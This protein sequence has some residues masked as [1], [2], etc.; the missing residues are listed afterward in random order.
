MRPSWSCLPAKIRRCW[1]AGCPPC[2]GSSPH[3]L[4]RV[5][6]LDA[7]RDRLARESLHKMFMPPPPPPPPP[8]P[9]EVREEGAFLAV[10]ALPRGSA[11]PRANPRRPCSTPGW[12]GVGWGGGLGLGLGTSSP[13]FHTCANWCRLAPSPSAG[14]SSLC[15][16]S[17]LGA[18]RSSRYSS[19]AS[20]ARPPRSAGWLSC[21]VVH[22]GDAQPVW[23]EGAAPAGDA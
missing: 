19:A 11:P 17:H 2:P 12:S 18:L 14:T 7:E 23:C 20:A 22:R 16:Q 6:R 10:S 8:P 15:E 9:W 4:D 13:V 1:W 3:V 5:R 21:A